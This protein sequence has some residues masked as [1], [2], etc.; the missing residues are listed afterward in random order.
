MKLL[1]HYFKWIGIG[2]II[3]GFC[4]GI[5][6]FMMGFLGVRPDSSGIY[7]RM[8]P[9]IF[10]R[11]SDYPMYLGLLIIIL[12]KS[13]TEDELALKLR[14]ESAFIVLIASILILIMVNAFNPGF[15]VHPGIF[16]VIQMLAYLIVRSVKGN[17]IFW[18]DYEEQA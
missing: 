17:V 18:D 2:F 12:S 10:A 9:E 5:D 11:I 13:K 7:E 1:P 16:I 8:L 6:D 4:L 14:Y 3:L 15:K